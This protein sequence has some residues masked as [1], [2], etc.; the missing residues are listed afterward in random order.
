MRM[1]S[2][3]PISLHSLYG[4]QQLAPE[5]QLAGVTCINEIS[6]FLPR[7]PA[8]Q[9][10]SC[11]AKEASMMG[12]TKKRWIDIRMDQHAYEERSNERSSPRLTSGI[13]TRL[14]ELVN[15]LSARTEHPIRG[16]ISSYQ[17]IERNVRWVPST[18]VDVAVEPPFSTIGS[19]RGRWTSSAGANMGSMTW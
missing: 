8:L 4:S 16:Q 15:I 18:A 10:D 3:T 17:L 13:G 6:P 12:G 11:M 5:G 14:V 1:P 2:W 7:A 19:I 9:E